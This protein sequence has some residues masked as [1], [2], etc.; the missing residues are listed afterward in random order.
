LTLNDPAPDVFSTYWM[1]TVLLPQS[2]VGRR[3]EIRARLAEQGIDTR[4]FFH[5]LSSLPAYAGQ[6]RG[7]PERNPTSYAISA[8][9]INL[10]SALNLTE[11]DVRE[12]AD[13]LNQAVQ[14]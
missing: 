7:G 12:V 13:A 4:P 14:V 8:R 3:D 1:V 11:D 10:P 6:G 9:G 2:Y 5:P